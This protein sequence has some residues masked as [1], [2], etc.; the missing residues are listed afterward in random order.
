MAINGG[1]VTKSSRTEHFHYDHPESNRE[2]PPR[3]LSPKESSFFATD[4]L[5]KQRSQDSADRE[6][7]EANKS[8]ELFEFFNNVWSNVFNGDDQSAEV[9]LDSSDT[10]EPLLPLTSLS[11]RTRSTIGNIINAE[12]DSS[13]NY[14]EVQA[15]TESDPL[16]MTMAPTLVNS[17]VRTF[18]V[19]NNH[20]L[21]TMVTGL[22][23]T[24]SNQSSDYAGS[25]E[26]PS[27]SPTTHWVHHMS[28]PSVPP[29]F[30]DNVTLLYVNAN[31]DHATS[32]VPVLSTAD[33]GVTSFNSYCYSSPEDYELITSMLC[34]S[35]FVLGI[36]YLTYGYR[37]F[38]A[39][40]FF[41]GLAFGTALAYAVCTAEHLVPPSY[42][43]GYGNLIVALAAGL[44][45]A[46][47]NMLVIYIGLFVI[48]FHLGL[49][50][51]AGM[52]IVIYLL[53]P[54]FVVLQP[55]LSALTLLIFFMAVSLVGA[56]STIYFSKGKHR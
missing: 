53:R 9:D 19:G 16:S 46:L 29:P 12:L 47:F 42:A 50:F 34:S 20:P 56:L 40:A 48:G 35:L 17:T 54:Y 24:S 27:M 37:C 28:G 6:Q 23:N 38:R 26:P 32:S 15:T 39:I 14:T 4:S 21:N 44:L 3:I 22:V 2:F 5:Y 8:P 11:N 49:L 41:T 36:V 25:N 31:H 13:V 10:N 30:A 52:L 33:T 45:V 7:E 51:G 43:Y 1:P 18:A 55:P